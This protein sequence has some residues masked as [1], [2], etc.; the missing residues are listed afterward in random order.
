MGKKISTRIILWPIHNRTIYSQTE[1]FHACILH[2]ISFNWPWDSNSFSNNRNTI[3]LYNT[4]ILHQTFSKSVSAEPFIFVALL[5]DKDLRTLIL[6]LLY[7]THF[8]HFSRGDERNVPHC[9][10]KHGTFPGL[11]RKWHGIFY[12]LFM[13]HLLYFEKLGPFPWYSISMLHEL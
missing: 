9:V 4:E 12:L 10:I 1:S 13:H 8:S 2:F 3:T 6:L 5:K 11:D 7:F